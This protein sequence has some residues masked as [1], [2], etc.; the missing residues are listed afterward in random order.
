[1][2]D[3]VIYT[4]DNMLQKFIENVK[5]GTNLEDFKYIKDF[6]KFR[7]DA[8]NQELKTE[9]ESESELLNYL[10]EKLNKAIKEYEDIQIAFDELNKEL[11]NILNICLWSIGDWS[12]DILIPDSLE[13]EYLSKI[14][15]TLSLE[16]WDDLDC[17]LQEQIRND[18]CNIGIDCFHALELEL[19]MLLS[20]VNIDFSPYISIKDT[21]EANII[22]SIYKRE[23]L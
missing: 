10:S 20:E 2:D 18:E 11:N 7:L 3:V 13:E 5:N 12:I 1:M 16:T 9:F 17:Y 8:Y 4:Y 22:F 14:Q 15:E 21:N 6:Q 23:T 19:D